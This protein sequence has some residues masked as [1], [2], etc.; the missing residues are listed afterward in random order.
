MDVVVHD[1]AA[2]VVDRLRALSPEALSVEALSL[3]EIFASAL[4]ARE[5]VA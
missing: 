1:G 4:G 2:G 3:E 5:A